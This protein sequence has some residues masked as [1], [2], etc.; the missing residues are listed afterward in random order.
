MLV[1]RGSPRSVYQQPNTNPALTTTTT[2]TTT[3]AET[4]TNHKSITAD[5][6]MTSSVSRA[7]STNNRR[8]RFHEQESLTRTIEVERCDPEQKDELFYNK[9]DFAR[10]QQDEQRRYDRMMMKKI[11]K[12]VHEQMADQISHARAQGATEEEIDAM[13]PQ[14]PEEIFAVLGTAVAD[15]AGG[16]AMMPQAP[17]NTMSL[18]EPLIHHYP[19]EPAPGHPPVVVAIEKEPEPNYSDDDIYAM[20]GVVDEDPTTTSEAM[21][22]IPAAA[23]VTVAMQEQQADES[24]DTTMVPMTA[25]SPSKHDEKDSNVM[26]P[27]TPS[28]PPVSENQD[29][30]VMLVPII[31][32]RAPPPSPEEEESKAMVLPIP[33][34][35]LAAAA[36]IEGEEDNDDA[37][38]TKNQQCAPPK[39]R[40]IRQMKG[41]RGVVTKLK[42][43]EARKLQRTSCERQDVAKSE[44]EPKETKD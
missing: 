43:F 10:F 28:A 14:T 8:I 24:H 33:P 44:A 39:N 23:P 7:S 32:A 36:A 38:T 1:A 15:A 11:Q 16:S 37:P 35:G 22:P 6:S 30:E 2:T 12:M 41:A 26:M 29:I 34:P 18:Y 21:E 4:S 25:P 17:Q 13:M 31:I 42:A 19:A 27:M 3:T 5:E 9:S 40:V 20:F